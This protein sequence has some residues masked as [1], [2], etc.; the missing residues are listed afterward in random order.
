V[1]LGEGLNKNRARPESSAAVK[2]FAALLERSGARRGLRLSGSG[3]TNTNVI[4]GELVSNEDFTSPERVQA[5]AEKQLCAAALISVTHLNLEQPAEESFEI[6]DPRPAQGGAD[7]RKIS[8]D[9]AVPARES[10]LLPVHA[11]LCSVVASG[12]RCS[13]EV[14]VAGAELVGAQRE[15]K[16]LELAFYAPARA[17]VR[18]NLESGPT[19]VEFDEGFRVDSEWKQEIGELEVHM[20]RGPAPDYRRVLRIHLRYTPHVIEKSDSAKNDFRESEFEVFDA[21]RFPLDTDT[22]IPTSPPLIA[23]DPNSAEAVRAEL[24]DMFPGDDGEEIR[25]Y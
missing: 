17:I 1:V 18:L 20:P 11:P 7:T 24:Q 25:R 14:I 8:F 6:S 2:S 4:A 23:V 12:G 15:G 10:L 5:C 22:T 19:K 9:V 21:I 13:D 3:E 16:T